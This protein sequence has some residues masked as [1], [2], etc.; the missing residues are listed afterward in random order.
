MSDWCKNI[1]NDNVVVSTRIRLA[2][3]LSGIP[4][5]ARMTDNQRDDL[6]LKVKEA[7]KKQGAVYFCAV[8]GAGALASKAIKECSVIA[9]PELGC[10]SVKKMIIEDFSLIVG[11]DSQG[12]SVF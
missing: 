8:G 9:F 11:I 3:N 2:R 7:I 10:E 4:F 6:K 12:N 1:S 5:P